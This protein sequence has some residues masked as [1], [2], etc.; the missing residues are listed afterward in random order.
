[1]QIKGISDL[2][3]SLIFLLMPI[4]FLHK[5]IAIFGKRA[6][7]I[8]TLPTMALWYLLTLFVYRYF[9]KDLVRSQKISCRYS[10]AISLA[11]GLSSVFKSHAVP[12]QDFQLPA[13]FSDRLLFQAGMDRK[14][15]E[16]LPKAASHGFCWRDSSD[17]RFISGIST[18]YF[19][20]KR[21]LYERGLQLRRDSPTVRA[22][23]LR[24]ADLFDLA[25]MDF[26]YLLI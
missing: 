15:P 20:W 1:M 19:L 9:L 23:L 17:S 18:E 8:L 12:R 24:I 16:R 4:M 14:A 6:L 11:A 7:S 5:V 3:V 22:S 26:P 10:I 21:F 13:V 25:G 2:S